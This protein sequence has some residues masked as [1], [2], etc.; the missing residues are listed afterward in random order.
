MVA[1]YFLRNS[2]D[3]DRRYNT[4]AGRLRNT[5][6]LDVLRKNYKQNTQQYTAVYEQ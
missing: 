5:T 4:A 3:G 6:A 1:I 2:S